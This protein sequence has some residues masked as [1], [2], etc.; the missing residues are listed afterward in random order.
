[1]NRRGVAPF[2]TCTVMIVPATSWARVAD[3]YRAFV[4]S[5]V[6]FMVAMPIAC[7]ALVAFAWFRRSFRL[8]VCGGLLSIAVAFVNG[9]LVGMQWPTAIALFA[10]AL[11][12]AALVRTWRSRGAS[13]S[14]AVR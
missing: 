5:S 10:V 12:S 9:L 7:I 3:E 1:M 13:S 4:E 14:P 8:S 11:A 2:A 6:L